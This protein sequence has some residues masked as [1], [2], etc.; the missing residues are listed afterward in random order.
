MRQL[1]LSLNAIIDA[2]RALKRP[3]LMVP[4]F[5][6]SILQIL[7]LLLLVNFHR[8]PGLLAPAIRLV[9]GD[10]A[11]HYPALFVAI[12]NLFNTFNLLLG[13]TIGAYLWGA[14]VLLVT[15]H[16]SSLEEDPWRLAGRRWGHLLLAQLP[17]VVLA[18]ASFYG[19]ALVLGD[20]ELHGNMLRL[21]NYGLLGFG[22]LV[23]SLFLFAPMAILLERMNAF[24]GV[25]R[26]LQMWKSNLLAALVV[27]AIPMIMHFPVTYVLRRA[28]TIVTKFSPET[29]ALIVAAD[30]VLFLLTNFLLLAAA[31]QVF[32]ARRVER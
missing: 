3:G 13:A 25:L 28:S 5:L 31:T 29:I 12:P 4:V 22:V 17:V 11:L 23:E 20:R 27:V 1:N 6:F 21:F 19:P 2:F 24:Q 18:L 8:L 10:A 14:G 9:Q 16:F 7:L 30:I 15:R 32:L 26:S